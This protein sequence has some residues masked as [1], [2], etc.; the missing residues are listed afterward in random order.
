MIRIPSEVRYDK[1]E[2]QSEINVLNVFYMNLSGGLIGSKRFVDPSELIYVTKGR[3]NVTLNG[4]K[5]VLDASNALIIK[6]YSIISEIRAPDAECAY[7]EISFSSTIERYGH[8]Y[9][10]VIR[11]KERSST[12]ESLLSN[13]SYYGTREKSGS[14]LLDSTLILILETLHETHGKE[15]DR[16]Q[17][18]GIM[19]YI[20]DNISSPLTIEEISGHFGYS[21]DYVAKMFKEQFGIT[22]KQ[23]VINRK[24]SVAKRLLT[25]SD[26]RISKVGEAI[27]FTDPVLFDK[28]FK[29]HAGMTPKKYRS[30]Y[31]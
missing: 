11:A 17:I 28:F 31:K 6:Q 23:Y 1:I 21:H 12:V 27:G 14:F 7:Y 10:E 3:L 8:M 4:R 16:L 22:I 30:V 25:T 24:L 18:H 26:L 19:E 2:A 13:L 9:S 5:Y 15:S 29:Y 20:N